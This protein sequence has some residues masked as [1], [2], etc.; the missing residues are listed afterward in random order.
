MNGNRHYWKENYHANLFILMTQSNIAFVGMVFQ[1]KIQ[2]WFNVN[3]SA[4]NGF[5]LSAWE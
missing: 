5:I 1:M 4:K 2:S 3:I